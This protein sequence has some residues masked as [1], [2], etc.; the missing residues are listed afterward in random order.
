M[1]TESRLGVPWEVGGK[2]RSR[3]EWLTGGKREIWGQRM[4]SCS[5]L[6]LWFL[7][8]RHQT[9][10][11]LHSNTCNLLCQVYL[12]FLKNQI[13]QFKNGWRTWI[14][15]S[16]KKTHKRPP[17][18]YKWYVKMCP[19]W[20]IIREMQIKTTVQRHFTSIRVT[21][22][23]KKDNKYFANMGVENLY[24][25]DENVEWCIH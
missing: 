1:V 6:W 5:W 4:C 24:T 12:N 19:T 9:W 16:P 7:W 22:I 17:D 3:R 15:I 8:G 10:Q 18:I 21:I 23:Q 25:V 11:I 2:G 13:P 14:D 20:L